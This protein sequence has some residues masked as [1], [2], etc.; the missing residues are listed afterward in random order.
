MEFKKLK[1]GDYDSIIE[2][3]KRSGLPIKKL[4]RDSRENILE[5]MKDDHCYEPKC[6]EEFEDKDIPF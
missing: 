1:F 2:V 3:W 5:Q 4:G 6:Y